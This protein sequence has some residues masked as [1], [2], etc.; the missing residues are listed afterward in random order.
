MNKKS[1]KSAI[2]MLALALTA[3][4]QVNAQPK[5]EDYFSP[6]T[7]APASPDAKGFI[8]R[9]SLL[10]PISKPR[11]STNA[12]FTDDYLRNEFTTVYFENQMTVVPV[13]GQKEKVVVEER[14]VDQ[15]ALKKMQQQAAAQGT[16]AGGPR[17]GMMMAPTYRDKK[18]T[19]KWHCY[20]SKN[21][22]VKL[23]RFATGLGLHPTEG[24]FWAVTVVNVPEDMTVRMSVGSNS[25]S[26]WWVNGEEA[27]LLSGD[28]RMVV[29][30]CVSKKITL[31]AGKNIIRGAVINGPGMSDFCVR[32]LDEKGNPVKNF[33]VTND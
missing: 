23:Y 28:R 7:A 8:Q 25:G 27:I 29:D 5:L 2:L 32:F 13:D 6:A 30:D 10:E 12:V 16:P 17:R 3:G 33:T 1:I 15:K 9:W 19:L 22:N 11:I 14:Y 31:K 20:D 21:Y 26:M 18:V 24:I 4:T